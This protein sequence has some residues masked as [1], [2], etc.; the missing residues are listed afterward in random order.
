MRAASTTLFVGP[1]LVRHH[2][3][4]TDWTRC[5]ELWFPR[6][7]KMYVPKSLSVDVYL[8]G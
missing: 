3:A 7:C 6:Q 8:T 4:S 5:Q 1:M 2:H